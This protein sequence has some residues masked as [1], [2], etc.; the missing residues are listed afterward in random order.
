MHPLWIRTTRGMITKGYRHTR[1]FT[2]D[3]TLLS[4]GRDPKFIGEKKVIEKEK[5]KKPTM[6]QEKTTIQ[7][8]EQFLQTKERRMR[9]TILI[10][11][12]LALITIFVLISIY[13]TYLKDQT[14]ERAKLYAASQTIIEKEK[15]KEQL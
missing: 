2:F 1:A 3:T 4:Y 8:L 7:T 6:V 12:G 13:V 11:G 10:L 5:G 15:R 9:M 14:N